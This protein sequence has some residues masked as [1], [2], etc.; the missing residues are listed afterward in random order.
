MDFAARF[1][2]GSE[3]MQ[4]ACLTVLVPKRALSTA[5]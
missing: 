3:F 2:G 1:R 4:T 5:Q